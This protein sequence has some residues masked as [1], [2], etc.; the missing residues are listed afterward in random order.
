MVPSA[1]TATGAQQ[2]GYFQLNAFLKALSDSLS[3][4]RTLRLLVNNSNVALITAKILATNGLLLIGSHFLFHRGILPLV[5]LINDRDSFFASNTHLITFTDSII[6]L[7]FKALWLFPICILCYV[8]S[9]IWYQELA[10]HTYSYLKGTQ[11]VSIAKKAGS[12]LYGTLIWLF[13]YVEVQLLT[14]LTPTIFNNIHPYVELFF[15]RIDSSYPYLT[16]LNSI[17]RQ[18]SFTSVSTLSFLLQSYGYLLMCLLYGWYAFDP[19][20]YFLR[21]T[22]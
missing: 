13:I 22:K 8:G 9:L 6:W 3:F 1:T 4:H 15:S 10:D 5:H 12:A 16:P 19:Q 14:V 11:K 7:I 21:L 20:V 2:G 17:L 18:I